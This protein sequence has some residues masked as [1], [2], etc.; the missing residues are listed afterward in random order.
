MKFQTFKNDEFI[1]A[2]LNGFA[3]NFVILNNYKTHVP[4]FV[5]A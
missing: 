2:K 4:V 3:E 1:V 5:L